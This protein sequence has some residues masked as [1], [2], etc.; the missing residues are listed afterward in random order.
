MRVLRRISSLVSTHAPQ[1]TPADG[2][3]V[4]AHAD[5]KSIFTRA[6][7]GA[8]VL[9]AGL[10]L[11]VGAAVSPQVAAAATQE[12]TSGSSLATSGAN[13]W[14][15]VSGQ[16]QGNT[17]KS[18]DV[19]SDQ[20]SSNE[21]VRVQKSV[22]PTGKENEFKV[23]L[24]IDKVNDELTEIYNAD[25]LTENNNS[26]GSTVGE[27][28][29]VNGQ[30]AIEVNQ[31][32][33]GGHKDPF[34]YKYKIKDT[35]G[36]IH[37]S[38]PI[39]MGYC[40]QRVKSIFLTPDA[41]QNS[42]SLCAW[43]EQDGNGTGQS[44]ESP[45]ILFVDMNEPGYE[46]VFGTTNTT[47]SL[48]KVSDPMGDHIVF[49]QTVEGDYTGEAPKADS[50]GVLN[51]TP[52]EKADANDDDGDGW[53]ENVAE[54]VYTITLDV[55]DEGFVSCGLDGNGTPAGSNACHVPTNGK[56]TLSY[57]VT[58]TTTTG[59]G[60]TSDPVNGSIDFPSPVVKGL[61]YDLKLKKVNEDG[62]GLAGAKF[63]LMNTD[64]T[65][66]VRDEAEV[67]ENGYL[68]FS[69]LPHGNYVLVET[70]KP[71]GHD[72]PDDNPEG[73]TPVTLCYTTQA[74]NGACCSKDNA[75][76]LSACSTHAN[77]AVNST[78]VQ[79]ANVRRSD[80][81]RLD[82]KKV[83][84]GRKWENDSFTFSIKPA[85]Y[86]LQQE[87]ET[88]IKG[89]GEQ[90]M[91]KNDEG[92]QDSVVIDVSSVGEDYGEGAVK[93]EAFP[94]IT[95]T[96]PGEYWYVVQEDN[97]NPTSDDL[98]YDTRVY[99]VNI[100]LSNGYSAYL[101]VAKPFDTESQAK[102]YLEEYA[103][104]TY[105]AGN[106]GA[107]VETYGG[108]VPL[109]TFINRYIKLDVPSLLNETKTVMGHDATA[110]EFT[111]T[112]EAKSHGQKG[113]EG[114][115]SADEAALLAGFASGS[116]K[117]S[118]S[119]DSPIAM[120]QLDEIRQ[121]NTLH[122]TV[123]NVGKTYEYWY[124]EEPDSTGAWHQVDEN[125]DPATVVYK[126]E[127]SVDWANAE[128]TALEATLNL[129]RSTD[130]GS[131]WG[132]EP[133]GI[134]TVTSGEEIGEIDKLTVSFV[135]EYG[136]TLEIVKTDQ[137]GKPLAGAEFTVTGTDN[138]YKGGPVKTALN[139]EGKAVAR[140]ENIPDGTYTITE[141]VPTGYQKINDMT[142]V[143]MNGEAHLYWEGT[144]KPVGGNG[145]V[146]KIEGVYTIT[147]MNYV[148]PDLPSTG[149]SGTV[150]MG[151]LGTAA[152]VLAGAWLLKQRGIDFSKFTSR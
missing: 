149:S 86:W 72:F 98:V 17:D 117:L 123:K 61:L 145:D 36:V 65:K 135:N 32:G 118:F 10:A 143:I 150:L 148:N 54:L 14:Q 15:I 111:F 59:G 110:N 137:D 18:T 96:Q 48:G 136:S 50:N 38:E 139:E 142:L 11:M 94:S 40:K 23:Y 91:P 147:I 20:V 68:E 119:N 63:K 82:V 33:S 26:S 45:A 64:G 122:F 29:L 76:Q 141:T 53:I 125:G 52:D 92:P 42:T 95:L 107:A 101:N 131:N 146:T 138:S 12:G 99:L 58:T 128:K 104:N 71:E 69:G 37:E 130:G 6:L 152:I 60:S 21:Y 66:V 39:F 133:L 75:R 44:K 49:G 1:P 106:S 3:T 8:V 5:K 27:T 109:P 121:A 124:A 126:A 28:A 93:S 31:D 22:V 16:Y 24:S 73:E 114:Y 134:V 78:V 35:D 57:T 7:Q 85:G 90:P 151:G 30:I 55:T 51:W 80:D 113:D 46:E 103:S 2:T 9:G 83:I 88:F 132:S 115:T 43:N 34:W 102:S 56:A 41:Q 127:V 67:N 112:V 140:F 62:E 97:E 13:E 89:D 74:K 129:Y 79:I 100:I 116:H 81:Y 25:F 87:D 84:D 120:N 77:N 19:P 70:Q 105:D 144:S 47:I 108:I 4:T